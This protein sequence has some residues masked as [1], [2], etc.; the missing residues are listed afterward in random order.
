MTDAS[1]HATRSDE[2]RSRNDLASDPSAL[3]AQMILREVSSLE[4]LTTQ[5]MDAIERAVEVAHNDLVRVPTDVQKSVTALRELLESR[6]NVT[7]E[8]F[9]SIQVQFTERDV[10][11]EQ[12]QRDSKVA[13]DAALQAAKEAVGE[14]NRSSAL[15]ISKSE[16]ST[17]K[18]LDQL[19]LL[20]SAVREGLNVSII[21][22]KERIA[23]VESVAQGRTEEKVTQRDD[24]K[25]WIAL[26]GLLVAIGGAV[27]GFALRS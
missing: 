20:I 14:Q 11:T 12:T 9:R 13:V 27:I 22:V 6:F 17:N 2:E 1:T 4:K 16:L 25:M 23:R 21:E 8:K 19:Q 26:A 3:T 5:R 15:A 18:Q 10:R 24:S 7:E